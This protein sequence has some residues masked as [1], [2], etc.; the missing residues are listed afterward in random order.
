MHNNNDYNLKESIFEKIEAEH[1]TP[2]SQWRFRLQHTLLW[3]PGTLVTTIGAC[4]WAGMLFGWNHAGFEYQH[5]ISPS[6]LEFLLETMPL[7]W[8]ISFIAFTGIIVKTLQLT[9][10]GYRFNSKKV[11]V[12]SLGISISVGTLLYIID[13]NGYKNQI[14][15]YPVEQRHKALWSHPESGHLAG[16][17]DIQENMVILTD[18]N[19]KQWVLDT[20][21]LPT[22]TT[23]T[24]DSMS[25]IVGERIDD[26]NFLVCV[27]LPW[28]LSLRP[29]IKTPKPTVPKIMLFST[30]TNSEPCKD[31]I[32]MSQ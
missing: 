15:R 21:F 25:R 10:K 9:P 22:T 32:L 26:N 27:I 28:N 31:L 5:F 17:I 3:I 4:A 1:I 14:I 11:L 12:L 23:I 24:D 2:T 30:T 7:I 20:S 13:M 19:N 18:L 8:I 6:K 16:L 29:N